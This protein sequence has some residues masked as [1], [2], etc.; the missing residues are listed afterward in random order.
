MKYHWV[1]TQI[2]LPLYGIRATL[3]PTSFFFSIQPPWPL[4]H[5]TPPP[6]PL[7]HPPP[8]PSSFHLPPYLTIFPTVSLPNSLVTTTL[9]GSGRWWHIWKAKMHMALLMVP[10]FLHHKPFPTT[11]ANP[12]YLTWMQQDQMVLSTIVSTISESHL[13]GYRLLHCHWSLE[14][15]RTSLLFTIPSP[16]H[17]SPLPTCYN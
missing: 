16:Y 5:Q 3:R 14:C 6:L 4:L 15:P 12:A 9:H 13:S 8:L 10:S 1:A 17:A 2:F 7:L 11:M